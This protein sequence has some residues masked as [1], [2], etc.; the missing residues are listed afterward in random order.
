MKLPKLMV[1]QGNARLMN[2][3]GPVSL[4]EI[5][6]AERIC[7]KVSCEGDA[8]NLGNWSYCEDVPNL[9]NYHNRCSA[10]AVNSLNT[11]RANECR[12]QGGRATAARGCRPW[13]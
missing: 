4:P 5:A 8:S 7:T 13:A 9:N 3:P 6:P 2:Y 11:A 1:P 10:L 12:R